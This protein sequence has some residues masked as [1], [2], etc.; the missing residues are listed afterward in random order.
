M[1]IW[2]FYSKQLSLIVL[3]RHMFIHK[4]K[5]SLQVYFNYIQYSTLDSQKHNKSLLA[6]NNKQIK[7]HKHEE[8]IT[9]KEKWHG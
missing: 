5:K 9:I 7:E 1:F 8:Q 2:L 6:E 4:L 3:F